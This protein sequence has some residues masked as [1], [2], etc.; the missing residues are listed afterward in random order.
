[1]RGLA[2][3]GRAPRAIVLENGYGCLTSHE[4]RDFAAI[5]SALTDWTTGPEL[6]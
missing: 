4:G 1:M 6:R 5:D 3:D 2:R